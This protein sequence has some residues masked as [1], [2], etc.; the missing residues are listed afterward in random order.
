MNLTDAGNNTTSLTDVQIMDWIMGSMIVGDDDF[1]WVGIHYAEGEMRAALINMYF[2]DGISGIA[3]FAMAM[4]EKY[5]SA[6]YE[7]FVRK[8]S[9]KMFHYTDFV[10]DG[11]QT[12]SSHTGIFCGESSIIYAYM[13]LY[14]IS[15]GAKYLDYAKKHVNIVLP[16]LAKDDCLD[17]LSGKAGVI[18]A[19]AELYK[20]TGD[21]S[22]VLWCEAVA[23]E[24]YDKADKD[25]SGYV[26]RLPGQQNALAGAAHGGSGIG[27]AFAETFSITHDETYLRMALRAIHGEDRFWDERLNNWVDMR[28]CDHKG[29]EPR[30]TVAWCHGAAG[31]LMLRLRIYELLD[32]P[33][34]IDDYLMSVVQKVRETVKEDSCLCHGNAGLWEALK[35]Y[36]QRRSVRSENED[37]YLQCALFA[38]ELSVEDWCNPGVMNGLAGIG[39]TIIKDGFKKLPNILILESDIK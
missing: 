35:Y 10:L 8:L 21:Y 22:L 25:E 36:E 37:L 20:L 14:K 12:Q 30:D 33:Y 23:A 29:K 16:L 39:Y 27:L 1:S 5:K 34:G 13:V 3:V 18:I 31:I 7:E 28:S 17:L 6:R 4:Y 26:W 32:I 19:L 2:Y 9:D 15:G 38:K 11:E 24:L